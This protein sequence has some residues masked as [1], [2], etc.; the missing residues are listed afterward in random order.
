M[1][2]KAFFKKKTGSEKNSGNGLRRIIAAVLS[3]FSS[4]LLLSELMTMALYVLP[5]V[6]VQ[7]YQMA[8]VQLMTETMVLGDM[9]VVNFVVLM[10]MWFFPT[11][12]VCVLLVLV[13]WKLICVVMKRVGLWLRIVFPARKKVDEITENPHVNQ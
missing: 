6:S 8:G 1:K 4:V 12:F 10:M 3:F 11:L 9:T 5:F 2:Q 7:M 13:H